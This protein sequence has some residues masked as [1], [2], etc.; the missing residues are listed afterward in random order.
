M[1][2]IFQILLFTFSCLSISLAQIT[3]QVGGGLAYNLPQSDAGGTTD[4]FYKGTKYGLSNGFLLSLRQE[5][6]Y[7]EHLFLLSLI[8]QNSAAMEMP[9]KIKEQ[10][11]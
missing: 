9:M 4:E 6:E 8:I 1:K 5:Q 3:A 7:S 11:S 10:L 2:K